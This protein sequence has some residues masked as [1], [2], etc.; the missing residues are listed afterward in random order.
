MPEYFRKNVWENHVLITV[1]VAF[2]AILLFEIKSILVS[3]FLAYILTST[4]APIVD[5][6]ILKK[7]SRG[8]AVILVYVLL[9]FALTF[10]IFP[11]VPFIVSQSR[12]FVDHFPPYLDRVNQLFGINPEIDLASFIKNELDI[13]GKNAFF[14]TSKVFSGLFSFVT[15]VVISIYLLLDRDRFQ[16]TFINFKETLTAL[17]TRLGNWVR[18]QIILSFAVGL[19]SW[20]GLTV[21]GV[22]FALPLA[23]IAGILEMVP[24]IGPVLSAVPAIIVALTISP[25][26]GLLVVGLYIVV[27]LLENNILVPKIM[28]QAVGLNPIIVILGIAIGGKLLGVLGAVLAIP[29]IITIITIVQSQRNST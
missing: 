22:P 13:L 25:T 6:L 20:L 9:I 16:K 7:F 18:G 23:I 27:Q 2:L 3:V 8:L 17:E 28:Q 5:Y 12:S 10:I 21:I 4:L 14:L 11:L 29:I 1:A 19:A 24:L 26:F 15:T